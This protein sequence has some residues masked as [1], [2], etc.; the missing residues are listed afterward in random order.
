[1]QGLGWLAHQQAEGVDQLV[2]ALLQIRQPRFD[3]GDL[4]GRFG[5]IQVGGH[6]VGQTQLRELEAVAGDVEVLL[7]HRA[8]VLYATQ[9]DVVLGGLGQYR[10]QHGAAVVFRHLQGGV[11][12]FGFA[13]DPTP[14]VQLPGRREAHIPLVERG[15]A[16][17]AGGVVQAFAAVAFALVG[18]RG[19]D[20][21]IT[22]GG[23]HLAHRTALLQAAAGQFQVEVIGQR[24]A[25]EGRQLLVVEHV[26]PALLQRITHCSAGG[27]SPLRFAPPRGLRRVRALKIRPD[28]AGTQADNTQGEPGKV[29]H[30]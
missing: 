3:G 5:N 28:S 1:V 17:F 6:A 18:A 29:S 20:S 19:V 4:G 2:L 9:L 15:T 8:G 27:L 26:P 16:V 7:G 22:L 24:A 10:Q 30:C 14:E 23:G 21:G 12:G 11:G 13:F 25:R